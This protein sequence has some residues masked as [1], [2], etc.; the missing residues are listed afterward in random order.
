MQ[1]KTLGCIFVL[2]V[3]CSFRKDAEDFRPMERCFTCKYYLR[4]KKELE[5]EEEEF[6]E[7]VDRLESGESEF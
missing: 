7:E 3:L 6:F 2:G 1:V 4:F 5:E